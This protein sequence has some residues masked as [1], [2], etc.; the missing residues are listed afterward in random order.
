MENK[1]IEKLIITWTLIPLIAFSSLYVNANNENIKVKANRPVEVIDNLSETEAKSLV[2]DFKKL[3][4]SWYDVEV[5]ENLSFTETKKMILDSLKEEAKY[6]T[7]KKVKKQIENSI[8]FLKQIEDE[9]DFYDNLEREYEKID[10][11]LWIDE[12]YDF[13][14]EKKEIIKDLFE[15][16]R[17]LKDNS[18]KF[19]LK[20]DI[21]K[22]KKIENEELF[23]KELNKI[24]SKLDSYYEEN[25]MPSLWQE[26]I[27]YNFED[28]KKDILKDFSEIKNTK[29]TEKV[30]KLEKI[31]DEEV[32]FTELDKIQIWTSFLGEFFEM[33]KK[34]VLESPDF[35]KEQKNKIKDIKDSETFYKT[36]E[37]FLKK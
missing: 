11:L 21:S 32:F 10:D 7:D 5:E 3:Q 9:D 23:F 14:S 19:N 26:M 12:T 18:L 37:K 29:L 16:I 28:T 8:R 4:E 36:V 25:D 20:K 13:V 15:E 30:K 35:T 2:N 17:L 1:N 34:A 31:K 27:N 6:Y 22:L 33:D 24:Y